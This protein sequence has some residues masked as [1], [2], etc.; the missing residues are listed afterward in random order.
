[1]HIHD[2]DTLLDQE[3]TVGP[4]TPMMAH[5]HPCITSSEPC[6][7]HMLIPLLQDYNDNLRRNFG[8]PVIQH[9]DHYTCYPHSVS[10]HFLL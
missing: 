8:I 3:P 7:T 9:F 5:V 2:S 6:I 1:M 4:L 10:F